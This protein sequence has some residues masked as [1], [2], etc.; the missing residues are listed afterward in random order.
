M[1]PSML[2]QGAFAASIVLG[3]GA[4]VLPSAAAAQGY[5]DQTPPPRDN[6]GGSTAT[7]AI[8]GGLGGAFAGSQ[9]AGHGHRSDGTLVG[10]LLGA[11]VGAAVGNN[12]GCNRAPPPPPPQPGYAQGYDQDAYPANAPPP[13]PPGNYAPQ[14]DYSQQPPPPSS[15]DRYAPQGGYAPPQGGYNQSQYDDGDEGYEAPPPPNYD[16][17]PDAPPPPPPPA[18]YVLGPAY[19]GAPTAGIV[20]LGGPR[21]RYFYYPRGYHWR[22]RAW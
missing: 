5:Y 15:Y 4:A 14:S 19:Y 2:M 13:P 3:L 22:H 1:K 12:A 6:C 20:V 11:A 8:V 21:Y 17:G 18:G 9:I 10:G 16:Y 7:G